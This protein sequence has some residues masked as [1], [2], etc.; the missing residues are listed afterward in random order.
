[1]LLGETIARPDRGELERERWARAM[2]ILFKPWRTLRDL[3]ASSETWAEAFDKVIFPPQILQIMKNM[4]V[5]HECK[6][7]RDAYDA[8]RKAGK[9]RPL[10]PSSS[11]VSTDV[12]SFAAALENDD[13]L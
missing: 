9:A 4:L 3:K 11:G 8:L 12:E 1:V 13:N 5:E 10:L 2:L 6:D 7:A